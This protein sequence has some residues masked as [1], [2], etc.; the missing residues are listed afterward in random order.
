MRD[1]IVD[2]FVRWQTGEVSGKTTARD[3]SAEFVPFRTDIVVN[4]RRGEEI[5]TLASGLQEYRQLQP[6]TV[7]LG[8]IL[9]SDL[10][11]VF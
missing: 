8:P 2:T 6:G 5:H 4:Q 9:Y 1:S 10:V 11:L 7:T 3:T